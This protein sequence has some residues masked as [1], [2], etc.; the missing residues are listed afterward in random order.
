MTL[1]LG[2]YRDLISLDSPIA[3]ILSD[4]DRE[5][6]EKKVLAYLLDEFG[7]PFPVE[8]PRRQLI[9]S[10]L[11]VRSPEPLPFDIQG[12]IDTLLKMESCNKHVVDASRFPRLSD[13]GFENSYC[14]L[15][16][17]D[18]TTI[19]IDAIVNAANSAL[20]GCFIPFHGCVDNAIHTAAGPRLRQDCHA[21]MK[22]QGSLEPTG[23]TKITRAYNLPSN[24]VLHTVGPIIS[25]HVSE[26]NDRELQSC[27]RSC[28]NLAAKI[29]AIRSIAF[30]SISTG[31]FGFPQNR[32]SQVAVRTV[33]QWLKDNPGQIDLVVFNVFSDTD[34]ECYVNA[35]RKYL[36]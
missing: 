35:F 24:Y 29:E 11:T 2:D 34:K 10:L 27:Y 14:A 20:L 7:K 31:I 26:E 18:I 36:S 28:L 6:V 3:P 25:G 15:W 19:R 33:N 17:G 12:S 9:Q 4:S 5:S 13:L 23:A 30:C 16:Q 8:L 32:A 22:K 21:I 1:R